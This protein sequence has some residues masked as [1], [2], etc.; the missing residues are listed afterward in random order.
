[1]TEHETLVSR[2]FDAWNETDASRRELMARQVLLESG[3]YTDPMMS[4][5]GPTQFA[6]MIGA[7]QTQMPGLKFERVG[8]IDATGAMVRFSWRLIDARG[9][10]FASGTDIGEFS[11]DSRFACITGFLD[12]TLMGPAWSVEKYAAFWAAPDL[13]ST[14]DELAAD[15]KGYWPGMHEPLQGVE[16]YVRPLRELLRSVPDFTLEVANHAHYGDTVFIRWIATGTLNGA[17]LSFDGV[18]CV[19][20]RNGRVIENRIY[21][22]HPLIHALNR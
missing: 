1:M 18:D 5:A 19:R 22:D 7:F 12:S 11:V 17:S 15:I 10:Q 16:A 8:D 2:Y 6:N 14:S 9:R 20:H 13:G 4:S 21:S 3:R